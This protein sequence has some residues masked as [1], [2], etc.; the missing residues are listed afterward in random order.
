[1][2]NAKVNLT[3]AQKKATYRTSACVANGVKVVI[4]L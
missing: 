4:E 2:C 3:P 1:M